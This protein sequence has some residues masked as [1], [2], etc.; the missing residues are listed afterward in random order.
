MSTP[1][2][3]PGVEKP[4]VAGP[5]AGSSKDPDIQIGVGVFVL[6]AGDTSPDAGA[7]IVGKRLGSMGAGKQSPEFLFISS[8]HMLK[9]NEL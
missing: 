9:M 6:Q 8:C 3:N 1:V 5:A 4:K 2:Q 7:F